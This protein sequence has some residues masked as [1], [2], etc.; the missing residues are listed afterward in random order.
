MTALKNRMIFLSSHKSFVCVAYLQITLFIF[1]RLSRCLWIQ[2]AYTIASIQ[3]LIW[4]RVDWGTYVSQLRELSLILR[5]N[6]KES[7]TVLEVDL[8]IWHVAS[9]VS[10]H[11]GNYQFHCWDTVGNLYWTTFNGCTKQSRNLLHVRRSEHTK[12]SICKV[13]NVL[14]LCG[15][16]NSNLCW[17]RFDLLYCKRNSSVWRIFWWCFCS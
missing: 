10:D 3:F 6:L 12:H 11:R 4:V 5:D 13:C 8:G 1:F 7:A 15:W 14:P 2:R 9:A 16:L 17:K